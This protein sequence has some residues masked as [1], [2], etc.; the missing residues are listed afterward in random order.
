VGLELN[1]TTNSAVPLYRQIAEQVRVAV[2]TG[3]LTPGEQ[4]PSV[5]AVAELLVVN[6]NTVARAYGE[7]VREGVAEAQ[8]GRGLFVAERRAILSPEECDRRLSAALDIFAREVL[9]LGFTREQ[10]AARLDAVLAKF[11]A[12]AEAK[13]HE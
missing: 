8:P 13:A 3:G 1:I 7:L 5:R 12:G 9:F 6:P 4:L 2:A 11:E 10:I